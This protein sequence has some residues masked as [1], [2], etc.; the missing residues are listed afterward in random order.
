MTIPAQVKR[1]WVRARAVPRPS[2]DALALLTLFAVLL[3]GAW[4]LLRPGAVT[5]G[6]DAVAFFYPMYAF[7]GERLR[8]GDLPGWNPYQFAGAPFAA[9]PE[10]GWGYLPAMV[11]FGLLPVAAAAKLFAALHLLLAGTGTY[12]LGRLFRLGPV[13]ALAAALAFANGGFFSDRLRCCFAHVQV[14]AWLPWAFVGVE[15]AARGR[16]ASGRLAGWSVAAVALGQ[17]FSGWLGQGAA[18]ALL[19]LGAFL[20]YR[21]AIEPP[22][23]RSSR[24]RR[25]GDLALHGAV[26][27]GLG[28][29]LAAAG[30]L[31]RIAYVARTNLADGY[32]GDPN[33]AWA[34][35]PGAWGWRAAATALLGPTGWYV[36]GA[37]TALALLAPFVAGRRHAVPLLVL[38]ALSAL[39]LTIDSPLPV[40]NLLFRIF[41][42]FGDLHRH[43][44]ERVLLIGFFAAALLAGA[45]VAALPRWGR[46]RRA[47]VAIAALPLAV[48]A[49]LA[50]GGV[51]VPGATWGA[52]LLAS[53]AVAA[54][55]RGSDRVGRLAGGV[56]VLLI[57]ADL[58]FAA[59]VN[60]ERGLFATTD[61]A[62]WSE[63]SA[64]AVVLGGRAGNEPPARFF[65]YDP[66]LA[67]K[68]HG[69]IILYRHNYRDSRT[70]ALLVNNRATLLGLAD[71]QGYNP[72]QPRRYVEFVTALNGRP[73]EYHGA[74]VLAPGLGSP[75]LDLLNAR[76]VVLPDPIPLG[77]TDLERLVAEHPTRFRGDGAR[78]VERSGALPRAWIVHEA[79]RVEVGDALPLLVSGAVD[80]RRTALLETE[81]PPLAP[82]G[83]PARDGVAWVAAEPDR[84]RLRT[85]TDAPGLLV[86][87]EAYDP[88]WVAAVD[89]R[90]VPVLVANHAL[91]ALPIPAG[92]H[93][94]ELRYEPAELRL[95]LVV[96]LAAA[97]TLGGMI[98]AALALRAPRRRS[99]VRGRRRPPVAEPPVR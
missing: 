15:V 1:S 40:S 17:I 53:A 43:R 95:G 39:L 57:A 89:G 59:R 49:G 29:A 70:V 21:V 63:P 25:L 73:Q 58:G 27:V 8:A 78:V 32:A 85:R 54:L 66:A 7:L 77:R 13:A 71:I 68:Q 22:R 98:V 97:A 65:G 12:L 99:V 4:D 6:L 87:S 75:L 14:A 5:V 76:H 83:D 51:S 20:V 37:V 23:W 91:R 41:P 56:L 67:T 84:L 34:T 90:P 46:P 35:D 88:G 60:V 81:P 47:S 16:G 61:L 3:G 11:A 42:A 50:L 36:G 86:L 2:G 74:Y 79:R 64:A 62:A 10:S 94:V 69:Q 9:D 38:L 48:V 92:S 82:T 96:T 26:V 31:P 28:A 44:P 18:Y 33:L 24:E 72:L 55:T 30:I 93:A 19:A 80:P 52:L 45:A